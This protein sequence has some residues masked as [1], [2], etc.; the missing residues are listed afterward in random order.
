[1]MGLKTTDNGTNGCGEPWKRQAYGFIHCHSDHSLKDS[2]LKIHDLISKAKEMGAAAVTLTDHG[3]CTGIAEFMSECKEAG[4]NGIPGVEAYVMDGY[5]D[6]AH[7]LLLAK[8]YRGYQ[9]ICQ[10]I[11]EAGKSTKTIGRLKLPVMDKQILSGLFGNGNVIACSACING[12]LASILLSDRE[13]SMK[14]TQLKRKLSEYQDPGD[15]AYLSIMHEIQKKKDLHAYYTSEKKKCVKLARRPFTKKERAIASLAEIAV[16]REDFNAYE[17]A[18]RDLEMEKAESEEAKE[19]ARQYQKKRDI[20]SV[21]LKELKSKAEELSKTHGKFKKTEQSI[22]V[23]E[24]RLMGEEAAFQAACREAEWYQALFGDDFFIELQYHGMEEE[25]YTMP[26]LAQIA[27]KYH[28]RTVATNDIHIKDQDQAEARAVMQAL[29]FEKW[30]EPSE[31]AKQLYLKSDV[32]LAGCLGEILDESTVTSAMSGIRSICDACHV[33]FPDDTHYPRYVDGNGVLVQHAASILRQKVYAGI[34]KCYPDGNFSDYARLEYELKTII[35][36]GYSDYFLIV[37]DFVNYAKEL[38]RTG[39]GQWADSGIG[40][41]VGP[42]RG[43]AV[44]SLVSYLLGITSVDPLQY[45]LLF[46]RFLNRD[47]VTM[48]DIDMD[49]AEEVREDTIRYAREKYGEENVASIRT[50]TTQAARASV[51]NCAR[52]RGYERFPIQT[53]MSGK[54]KDTIFDM[55]RKI[56]HL[57]DLICK[58]IPDRPGTKL[59]DCFVSLWSKFTDDD[60]HAILRRARMVEDTIVAIGVHPAGII[61]G[62]GTPIRTLAPLLNNGKDIWPIQYNMVEAEG[63]GLLKMDFLG[64]KN[65]DSNTE[66]IRKVKKLTGKDIDLDHLPVEKEVIR[67][68]FSKGNT[69]S[70][71][72]FESAGMR[73]MLKEFRPDGMEDLILLVAAYRPGPMKFIPEI[74]QVKNGEKRPYYCMDSLKEILTPTYG[75]PIYQEQLMQIFHTCA[76]F[77]LGEADIIRR[78]MS[79][80]K[81]KE[82]LRYKP[83]FL[84]GIQSNGASAQDAEE[85]WD[86]LVDFARYGFNK[87]HAAAYAVISY[88]SAWLKF[89]YPDIYMC[90]VLNHS[91][92]PKIPRLIYECKAMGLE[93]KHPDVNMSMEGFTA[94]DGTVLYGIGNI[95]GVK[96]CAAAIIQER[97][98]NG[99][100]KDVPDFLLRCKGMFKKNELENLVFAGAFDS[101][102]D[103]ARLSLA[104]NLPF[105]LESIKEIRSCQ[106]K[107]SEGELSQSD[108]E[109]TEE[110]V[111]K[112]ESGIKGLGIGHDGRDYALEKPHKEHNLLGA[113]ISSHPLD[114]YQDLYQ[115]KR[116]SHISDIQKGN[117]CYI[118]IVVSVKETE[119]KSDGKKMCLF[120]MEDNSGTVDAVCFADAYKDYRNLLFEGNIIKV[121]AFGRC[122]YGKGANEEMEETWQLIVRDVS[123]CHP[124]RDPI[125]VSY[126]S[127]EEFLCGAAEA[128]KSFRSE[129]GHPVILHEQDTGRV[130]RI[131]LR[132]DSSILYAGISGIKVIQLQYNRY[133]TGKAEKRKTGR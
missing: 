70:V 94:R 65:L 122:Q 87:S 40:Y 5:S 4:I 67:E 114:Q 72:Q 54:E 21:E 77:S 133:F 51:R 41:G 88:Q 46:E 23:L 107:L 10:A 19:K 6:H 131:E 102:C 105:Y 24:D 56:Q 113:Y 124:D 117:G 30:E 71:F 29:R 2:P 15:P 43:S 126:R 14:L 86:S 64:L 73:K 1:M 103:S 112:L 81:E 123:D 32:E 104:G 121:H 98:E 76:G 96:N 55:R 127:H 7:L 95:K 13:V 16:T 11:T 36:L 8:N 58:E 44:G 20:L 125:L 97:K 85:L 47:R 28:I 26:K 52:V 93:V 78:Y 128:I 89:H 119:R 116:I 53:G 33:V 109:K 115:D 111:R 9:E 18:K 12:T 63:M 74:I 66:C 92:L 84:E 83:K 101:L 132:V 80:K 48:P 34:L 106:K 22:T 27:D 130:S 79:K 91:L 99:F 39:N 129:S 120:S 60:S 45:N 118:G 75:Y 17:K 62:D 57:G 3:T 49:Y 100:F 69:Q 25:A 108:S 31:S 59:S 82:F 61:I 68:I 110:S 35:D 90:S 37:Q 50:V 38:S 42:G